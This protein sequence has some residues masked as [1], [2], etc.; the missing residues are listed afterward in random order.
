[1][2]LNATI[3]LTVKKPD[4]KSMKSEI[5]ELTI[6]A[7]Q[8]VMQF[9]EFSPEALKAEKALAGA[10]DRME[11]FNDRVKAVNPDKFSKINTVVQGVASGFAAAQGAMALFGNESKDFEKTMIKLQG[12]MALSQGLEGLGKIQQQFGAIFKDVVSGAKKAFAA[13][14][15]GIG[16]TGIGLILVALGAIVAYWDDIKEAVSGVSEEQKKLLADAQKAEKLERDKLDTLNGQDSILKLQGL[17]EEEILKLKIQQ[18]SA[19][20][21]QLEAQLTAQET[22][23]Q[24]QIDTAKRNRDILQGMIRFI[25]APLSILLKTVDAVGKALNQDFGLEEKFSK[26]IAEMVFDPKEVAQEADAAIAET[27]KQLNTLKNTN[28][29]YQLSINAIHTKAKEDK[30][31]NDDDA[32]QKEL[33]R[34][35]KLEEHKKKMTN[36]ALA[37][38]AS[39]RDAARQKELALIT[40]EGERIDKEYTN[41]LAALQEAKAA[42]L[43]AVGDNAAAIAAIDKKY[44]DLDI[45][46]LAEFDA[47]EQKLNEDAAAKRKDL[48]DK[49]TADKADAAAKALA[50]DEAM[51]KSKQD[52]FDASMALANAVIGLVGEQSKAG[53]VLALST[54]AADTAMSISNAMTTTSSPASP[55]NLATGGIAGVAKYIALAAM[56]LNN[57]KRAKDILK[58]GQPSASAPA[59][60]NGGGMPQMS[61]PNISS[62][63][64]SVSGF[65]TKV[66]V[67]E[68]D[69]RRTTDR[70]DSTRK[71]SVV[72]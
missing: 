55:D 4:F 39:A 70:V 19:V 3:D 71:V 65:D 30:K 69:I 31:K 11:D 12:A 59:Q 24:S 18:T 26:G 20:I 41:K 44:A 51:K 14:K 21:T 50:A 53:K 7:Q 16:S 64:P 47:A 56:I 40:D 23:K 72:K 60:M 36:D 22:M 54:I 48:L 46:A 32:A 35:A 9:G 43:K 45:V 1:M 8:A 49:E 6:Q 61:A 63:L 25:F 38:E 68:G 34:L 58:G 28:A 66:F 10:R 67:T 29:G 27:K 13:I 62:S 2:A 42:E 57:A 37:A 52:L 15:A 17:T 33:D 5:K